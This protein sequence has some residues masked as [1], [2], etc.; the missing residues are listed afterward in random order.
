MQSKSMFI[1]I[2]MVLEHVGKEK[3]SNTRPQISIFVHRSAIK[4]TKNIEMS[5]VPAPKINAN[6]PSTQFMFSSKGP[7][8]K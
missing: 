2:K 1:S 3:K 4:S 5:A 7:R 8:G 6:H